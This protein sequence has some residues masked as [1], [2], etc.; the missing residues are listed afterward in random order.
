MEIAGIIKDTEGFPIP[1]AT[2]M[3]Q[4][5][6]TGTVSDKNGLFRLTLRYPPPVITLVCSLIGYTTTEYK[7]ASERSIR[8]LTLEMKPEIFAHLRFTIQ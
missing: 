7:I 8:N 4:G 3:L 2:V 6:Q 1:G 5:T